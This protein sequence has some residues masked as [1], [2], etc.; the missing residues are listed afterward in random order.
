M[1]AFRLM[2]KKK[3]CYGR[4][5]AM[6]Y[7]SADIKNGFPVFLLHRNNPNKGKK[8]FCFRINLRRTTFS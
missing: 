7:G 1:Q 3:K 5:D 4:R 2:T 6:T 8:S